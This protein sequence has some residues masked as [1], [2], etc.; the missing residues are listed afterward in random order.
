MQPGGA[1]S[2]STPMPNFCAM[3]CCSAAMAPFTRRR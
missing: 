2:S 1:P 3:S